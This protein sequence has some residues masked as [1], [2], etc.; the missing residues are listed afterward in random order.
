MRDFT[1]RVGAPYTPNRFPFAEMTRIGDWFTA[2]N[3]EAR[4]LKTTV[5]A[6]WNGRDGRR[7]ATHSVP[8]GTR[9]FLIDIEVDQ[10]QSAAA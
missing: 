1:D 5:S 10:Q 4:S 2:W 6:H 8:G 9:V 3:V 7:F